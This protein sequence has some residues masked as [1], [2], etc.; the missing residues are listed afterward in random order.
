MLAGMR[1]TTSS[2]SVT[3]KRSGGFTGCMCNAAMSYFEYTDEATDYLKSRDPQL[4]RAIDAVGHVY[5]EMDADLFSAVVHHIIGQQISTAA[6]QTVW[7]RMR[8]LLGEV[9][10]Q[11]ITAASPEQLQSCG[12]SFRK[13]D[14]I[15]DFAEK[16]M[17]G[18]FDLDA[19]EQASDAEAIAA[20][21]S[22]RGIG[23]WTAEML[24]LFCL[25]RP[26]VLSFDDLAIQR[27][28]RM[29]YHHRK[30]TRP[31]FEKYRRRY[32]PYGSVASLYLWAISSM[33]IPGYNRDY[34]PLTD[35]QKKTARKARRR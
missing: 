22:L 18:S 7:L 15:Q 10:A 3:Y 14:Y 17:N 9:S 23:T 28:L 34:A 25:G 2:A 4:A 6:Q 12:I 11:S 33:T 8:E 26:D 16:V 21:S 35:A 32:S 24:L 20:L 1:S 19:I 29:V 13:V 5:R 31:L 30:I 27:G